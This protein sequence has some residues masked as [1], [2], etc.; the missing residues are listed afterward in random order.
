MSAQSFMWIA[1]GVSALLVALALFALLFRLRGTLGAV[2][3]LLD[4]TSDEMKETLPE[5][6]QTIGD[7]TDITAGLNV[8]L[9]TVGKGAQAVGRAVS[10]TAH[11]AKVASQSLV[12]SFL[13]G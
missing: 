8:G 10:A 5:V 2:Q 11:G 4:T 9:R 7:V 6:R 1:F 3:E 12:R 13:G